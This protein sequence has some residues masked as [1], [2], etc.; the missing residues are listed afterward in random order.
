MIVMGFESKWEAKMEG[1]NLLGFRVEESSMLKSKWDRCQVDFSWIFSLFWICWRR[2][3]A[4][5][6]P[7]PTKVL[8]HFLFGFGVKF[9][10]FCFD[11]DWNSIYVFLFWFWFVFEF[12]DFGFDLEFGKLLLLSWER[13]FLTQFCLWIQ[14]C[15]GYELPLDFG[16]F[17]F[18][19]WFFILGV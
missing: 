13:L 4:Q 19:F 18:M 16:N 1:K 11:L 2:A 5:Q 14:Q 6:R 17:G 12:L 8:I 3:S 10:N 9:L 7:N 15:G